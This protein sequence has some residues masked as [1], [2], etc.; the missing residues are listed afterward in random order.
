[1]KIN[2]R[3]TVAATLLVAAGHASVCAN[4]LESEL[5]HLLNNHPG[6][7]AAKLTVSAANDRVR[8]ASSVLYPKLMLSGDTGREQISS[9]PYSNISSGWDKS[10][11]Q[12]STLSRERLSLVGETNLYSGGRN[13]ATISVAESETAIQEANLTALTQDVLFEA[14]TA[15]LQ[16]AR[17]QTLIGLARLNEQTT[18]QQ[19]ELEAKRVDG[20][21]GIAVDVLQARTR[22][23]IVRERRV[24]YEQGLRDAIASYEQ[25]FGRS[26]NLELLQDVQHFDQYLPKSISGAMEKGLESSARIKAAALQVDKTKMMIEMEKSGLMPKL[27]LVLNHGRSNNVLQVARR[28]ESSVLLRM[29]WTLYSGGETT[30]RVS[31]AVKDSEE[32]VERETL[33]KN[34]LRETIRISWNQVINGSE[35]LEL[36]DGA[37]S[38]SKDVMESRKRLRDAGKESALIVLDAEVEYFGVLF[39]KVNAMYDTRL[40]IYRLL[41]SMGQLSP[42]NL[43]LD[44][45]FKLP[46]RPLTVELEKIAAPVARPL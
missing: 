20:G 23:Q 22:L 35:R 43:G 3:Q 45:S 32:S 44:S 5:R 2:V 38:I 42:E 8:A 21:G 39:N 27:D 9:T 16:V 4:P 24:F 46:V 34:K 33:A 19:L 41:N 17:Y 14:L 28:D 12:K 13:R 26:P 31:A 30:A 6:L 37:A 15:Y 10:P 7:K 25:V 18:Q 11:T 1:M 36:L 29:N 40:G